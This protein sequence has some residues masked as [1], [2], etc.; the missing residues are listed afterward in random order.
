[1]NALQRDL[2]KLVPLVESLGAEKAASDPHRQ[3]F[4]IQPM[5]GWLN[6]PNGLC[7]IGDTYHAFFQ[8]GPFDVNGGVKHWGH[9]TSR[10]L[11][12][13]NYQPT[14]LY[15]DEPFDCHGVYSGSALVED[16]TMY[17]Y[18][19]G[20][21]KYPGAF[22]YIK[23]GRGH[24]VC[25]A[26]SRDGL[27]IDSKQ[28]LMYNKDYPAGL[29]CHVRDPKV[30]ACEGRYY[31]VLGARTVEDRGEVLVLE[32]EDK[33]TWRHTNTLTTPEPFGFMWECPDLFQLDG[34][35][36][37]AVSPQGIE[38]QNVYGCGYFPIY[39]DW[40]R[41]CILGNFHHTDL[42]FDYYAPQSFTDETGRRIQIG[43]M[44]MPDAAYGN[45]A[46]VAYG[47]QHCM[48]IPRVLTRD[49]AGHILQNPVSE[50]A[51]RRGIAV[52]ATDG[53]EQAVDACFDLVAAPGGDF[54]LG[55]DGGL[56]LAYSDADRTCCLTFTDAAMSGGRTSRC[57][58]LDAP[59]R[60]LRVVGDASSLE[61]FL[62]DGA[63][64]LST[65]YYPAGGQ[66]TL[67]PANF[68]AAVY[69]LNL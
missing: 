36:F 46:T 13:W 62:N 44:G 16:G 8:Y 61:I 32:S 54:S 40:R 2:K 25:L 51:A 31:M 24:N 27:H 19:T 38:C 30:F 47:W 18:Y 4:H 45:A 58:V 22:D 6:D 65:R 28:C 55:F 69:P 7:K 17:L 34:Q 42:G 64:V 57:V 37:L 15:P 59:C 35:W 48:T 43:W 66:V 41:D 21:V 1:M 68:T 50:L 11:L 23:Q 49:N 67:R 63:A 60:R 10:D 53:A 26:V 3:K 39:G 12:H 5:V 20:N 52:T 56:T 14:M 9:V 29:T 33:Y